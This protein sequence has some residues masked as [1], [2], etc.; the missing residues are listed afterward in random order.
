MLAELSV[1]I[2]YH[3]RELQ[4]CVMG[5]GGEVIRNRRVA[6]DVQALVEVVSVGNH[7]VTVSA[8]ACNGSAT[9]LDEVQK[10]TGWDV[11]LCHPGYAQRM[12]HNPDKSDGM[13]I[14]DLTR[15]GCLPEVWLAPQEVRDL[16]T[17]V[18]YRAS[19]V[20]SARV[21]KVRIRAL[22]RNN[23]V[24]IPNDVSL[25]TKAGMF[26]LENSEE[27][28]EHSLWVMKRYAQELRRLFEQI[29][30]AANR[31]KQ[32]VEAD[33]LCCKL[34]KQKGIGVITAAVIRA[35]IGTFSRFSNGKQLA[36]FC[37]VTPCN[38]SSGQ[39]SADSG[40]I[41]AGNPLLKS[42]ITQGALSLIRYDES[43][44][45]FSQRL[46]AAGKPKGVVVAAVANRWM[47]KLFH[48]F[49]N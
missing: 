19:L 23:R 13:L 39:V 17:L 30:E 35:E 38:R 14:A 16:R 40:L 24:K 2:D 45:A 20:A 34:L 25:W 33:A 10:V 15:V 22:L 21:S 47:R 8:E 12:R 36:R 28:P 9:F 42:C 3:Q 7:R 1:G 48:E 6:N 49:V 27:L 37:G 44:R 4:V 32:Y 46:L 5:S 11:K 26:W 29:R 18:R 43:W 31:I 41:R